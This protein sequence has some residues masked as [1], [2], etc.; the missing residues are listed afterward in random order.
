MRQRCGCTPCPRPS[1]WRTS[2]VPSS[3]CLPKESRQLGRAAPARPDLPLAIGL[4]DGY[5]TC[6]AGGDERPFVRISGCITSPTLAREAA[7]RYRYRWTR[8]TDLENPCEV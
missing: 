1:V 7:C 4:D 8:A 3:R 6:I 2:P 5:V